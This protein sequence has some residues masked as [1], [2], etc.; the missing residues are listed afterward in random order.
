[1]RNALQHFNYVQQV[2]NL[3]PLPTVLATEAQ[4][5]HQRYYHYSSVL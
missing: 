5:V 4:N 2:V 3:T 1:M